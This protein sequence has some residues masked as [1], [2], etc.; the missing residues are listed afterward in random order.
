MTRLVQVENSGGAPQSRPS[1]R[2]TGAATEAVD[3]DLGGH[4]PRPS[5]K[6]A[7]GVS[8]DAT[9]HVLRLPLLPSIA[10]AARG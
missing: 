3:L 10:A 1:A 2:P 5:P 8:A 9:G 6:W 4:S 7:T